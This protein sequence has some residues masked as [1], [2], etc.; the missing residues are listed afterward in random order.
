MSK[1]APEPLFK[2]L[3]N[4]IQDSD[5]ENAIGICDKSK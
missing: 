3:D 1:I 4:Y 2:E 5:F